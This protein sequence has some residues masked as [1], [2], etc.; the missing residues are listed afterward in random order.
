LLFVSDVRNM[1]HI[2]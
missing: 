2:I 1:D